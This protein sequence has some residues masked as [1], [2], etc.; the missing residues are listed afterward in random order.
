[1]TAVYS[2]QIVFKAFVNKPNALGEE[3]YKHANEKSKEMLIPI[4]IFAV[5]CVVFGVS[6][7]WFVDLLMKLFM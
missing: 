3:V 6:S 7:T 2:L 5:I 4:C 1:M